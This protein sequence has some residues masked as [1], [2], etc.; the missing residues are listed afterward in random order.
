M[1]ADKKQTV[2]DVIAMNKGKNA[3]VF[4]SDVEGIIKEGAKA[5]S[6]VN[7]KVQ[8]LTVGSVAMR[9]VGGKDAVIIGAIQLR[10][11]PIHTGGQKLSNKG[12]KDEKFKMAPIDVDA[13]IR[14]RY[15]K[16]VSIGGIEF[17]LP[18]ALKK[19]DAVAYEVMA[20]DI[21]S[22]TITKVDYANVTPAL[23][24][25]GEL[26]DLMRK[27]LGELY[28]AVDLSQDLVDEGI[29]TQT[30]ANLIYKA[31]D[32]T[33][34]ARDVMWRELEGVKYEAQNMGK[35][36]ADIQ[37]DTLD[38]AIGFA[39]D[40]TGVRVS[41]IAGNS[42][43]FDVRMGNGKIN[44]F[45]PDYRREEFTQGGTTSITPINLKETNE[46]LGKMR[47]F[48]LDN[49]AINVARQLVKENMPDDELI[50]FLLQ[51]GFV[52]HEIDQILTELDRLETKA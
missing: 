39:P 46:R 29:L 32:D 36:Y 31:T 3:Y 21:K 43:G 44:P 14:K 28:E 18:T 5:L 12:G 9:K 49:M 22:K 52:A 7:S 24:S 33:E 16:K 35:S 38:K 45:S 34:Y 2:K 37:I 51:A 41:N 20:D 47:K 19:I 48:A 25:M 30:T 13:H 26:A 40:T 23:A 50:V 6:L 11:R 17:D 8:D 27:G 1:T 15:G 42:R 10:G 4:Y